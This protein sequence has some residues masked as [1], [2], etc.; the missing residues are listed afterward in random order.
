[1]AVEEH[2]S[3]RREATRQRVLDAAR[4]AFAEKGVFG[5]TIED[6]VAASQRV[7]QLLGEVAIGAREQST[8]VAQVGQAVQ[9]LD[10]MTQQNAML[11]EDTAASAAAMR[12]LAQKLAEEVAR[13]T[14]PP[15]SA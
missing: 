6:I 15:G 13:F 11:V 5:A 7:N 14:L 4:V 1:M 10:R 3:A 2:R 9:E 8:G 12:E